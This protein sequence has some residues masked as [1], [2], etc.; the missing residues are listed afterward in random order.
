LLRQ[1]TN[2]NQKNKN[3]FDRKKKEGEIVK[4]KN[5]FKKMTQDKK[6]TN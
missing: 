5:Q 3:K 6:N 2:S 4:K 1:K